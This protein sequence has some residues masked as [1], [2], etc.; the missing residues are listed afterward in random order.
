MNALL[1]WAGWL[2]G[3][4]ALVHV[5]EKHLSFP[6]QYKSGRPEIAFASHIVVELVKDAKCTCLSCGRLWEE[7]RDNTSHSITITGLKK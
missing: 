6:L 5:A 1:D 3:S 7:A 2:A 4:I